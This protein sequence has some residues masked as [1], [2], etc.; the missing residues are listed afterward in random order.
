MVLLSFLFLLMHLSLISSFY[1]LYRNLAL[2]H[3][4]SLE[5]WK[6]FSK[7][8]FPYKR[9]L[10]CISQRSK[11]RDNLCVSVFK[12]LYMLVLTYKWMPEREASQVTPPWKPFPFPL[13]VYDKA[14]FLP[15]SRN[16]TPTKTQSQIPKRI[17]RIYMLGC[18]Y[19]NTVLSDGLFS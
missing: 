11:S 6:L 3:K 7:M 5:S 9:G 1:F 10:I 15:G 8:P 18:V 4:T 13:P 14:K 17:G 19:V 12:T 16:L 2:K